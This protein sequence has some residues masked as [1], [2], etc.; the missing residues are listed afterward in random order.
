MSFGY[1]SSSL[2]PLSPLYTTPYTP[3]YL[4]DEL[5]KIAV[6]LSPLYVDKPIITATTTLY[7]ANA[8]FTTKSV[9]PVTYDTDMDDNYF[10]QKQ[11][12]EY[13]HFRILD[14][15]LYE[16]DMCYLLK[17]LQVDGSTVKVV[18]TPADYKENRLCNDTRDV[19]EKKIDFIQNNILTEHKMK[20]IIS[21]V[22]YKTNLRWYNLPIHQ[23]EKIIVRATEKYLRK[24][25][26]K[27]LGLDK[28]L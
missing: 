17:Y 14:K 6:P 22:I 10:V 1:S 12:T 5:S 2:S 28:K 27:M 13:L 3:T 8:L 7:P 9:M 15:W 25:F 4:S 16:D 19:V 21:K 18:N 24:K 11:M 20:D 26:K 23:N